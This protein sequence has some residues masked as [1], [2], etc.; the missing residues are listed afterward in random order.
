MQLQPNVSTTTAD[1]QHRPAPPT[2]VTT[3]SPNGIS[4]NTFAN[5][6]ATDFQVTIPPATATA[7]MSDTDTKIIQNPQIRA[8]DGQ[9]ATLEDRRTRAGRDGIVPARHWRRRHQPAW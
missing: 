2:T 3:T 1:H 5:L 7:L 6:N 9:K 4:L 8:L